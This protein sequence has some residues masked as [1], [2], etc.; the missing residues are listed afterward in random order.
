MGPVAHAK[1]IEFFCNAFIN[2]E[3][4]AAKSEIEAQMTYFTYFQCYPKIQQRF[5]ITMHAKSNKKFVDIFTA[6]CIDEA[7]L[8]QAAERMP[9]VVNIDQLQQYTISPPNVIGIP[10]RAKD[11]SLYTEKKLAQQVSDQTGYNFR[12]DKFQHLILDETSIVHFHRYVCWLM[13]ELDSSFKKL[14]VHRTVEVGTGNPKSKRQVLL[15]NAEKAGDNFDECTVLLQRVSG[16]IARLGNMA[17]RT[18]AFRRYLANSAVNEAIVKLM[19]EPEM[20]PEDIPEVLSSFQRIIFPANS[21][22]SGS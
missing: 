19:Q 11:P 7:R 21:H 18:Y 4:Q 9:K 2:A 22:F 13:A 1:Q 17:N 5:R 8:S 14:V 16:L 20:L 3:D 6:G 10:Y 12:L 15:K